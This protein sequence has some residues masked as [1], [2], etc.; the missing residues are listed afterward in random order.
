MRVSHRYRFVFLAYPRT[1]SRSIRTLLAPYSDIRSVHSSRTSRKVP[2]Y[3]HMPASEAK[4]VFD[5]NHWN[6]FDYHRFCIVRNPFARIV[7]LYHHYLNMRS[8]IAPD[9]APTARLK[10]MVKYKLQP[11]L[12][13]SDYVLRPDKMRKIAMPLEEFIH[14]VDGTCLLDDIIRFE[15]IAEDLP[16]YLEGMGIYITPQ[17][18]PLMGSSDVRS[19]REYYNEATES[20]VRELY[21]Y[22]IQRFGYHIDDLE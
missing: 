10:A 5:A 6:W 13:F 16:R 21:Q 22:E 19:Y 1:A 2:F 3:H 11:R 7:S 9:L 17:Q 14:D 20:F 4:Q 12:S 8:R 18:I 15:T